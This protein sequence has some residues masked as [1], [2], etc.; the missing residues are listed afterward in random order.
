M[1]IIKCALAGCGDIAR[2][3]YFYSFEKMKDR[4]E[5]IGV[6]DTDRERLHK[7]AEELRVKEYTSWEELL[8]DEEV[9][10]VIVT[11]YHTTHA[12]LVTEALNA[13]KHVLCEKP[14]ATNL[15][16][17]LMIKEASEKTS[18]ILMALPNDAYTHIREVKKMIGQGLIGNVCAVDG[19]FAHQGPLHA[20]WFFD[21]SKAEWGVLADLGIYPISMLTYLFGPV[22]EVYGKTNIMQRERTSL[23]GEKFS[24]TVEDNA[25]AVMN[26]KDG[27]VATIRA[28][29]CT[30]ADKDLCV[31]DFRIYGDKGIIY[32]NMNDAQHRVIVYSPYQ[33]VNDSKITYAGFRDCYKIQ[34]DMSDLNIDILEEFAEAVDKNQKFPEDGCSITRQIHV[35]EIIEGVYASSEK[36]NAVK[37]HSTFRH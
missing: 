31:W 6:Y 28:N 10:A 30:A 11:S 32:I 7:T 36:G 3:R 25:V 14:V 5:L 17:A 13:G 29:W 19:V 21:K 26:W 33:K 37:I 2:G 12:R 20:P 9:E 22:D 15:K 4:T 1:R 27:K 35:V 34:V 16:D 24:P 18:K 23:K 8:Q